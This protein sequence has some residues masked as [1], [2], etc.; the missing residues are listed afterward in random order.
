MIEISRKDVISTDIMEFD[1]AS[2]FIKL[3]I[4]HYLEL[5]GT[6]P[7]SAQIALINALNNPILSIDSYV[8]LFLDD[9]VKLI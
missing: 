5:L 2:R 3:P 1:A 4:S 7:N 8:Q 9:K 6:V